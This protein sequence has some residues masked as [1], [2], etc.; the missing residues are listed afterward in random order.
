MR[1]QVSFGILPATFFISDLK[2]RAEQ[3][4]DAWGAVE[5]FYDHYREAFSQSSHSKGKEPESKTAQRRRDVTPER[6]D[7]TLDKV[8][9]ATPDGK[10]RRAGTPKRGMTPEPAWPSLKLKDEVRWSPRHYDDT[11]WENEIPTEFRGPL[12]LDM[13]KD[14]LSED[15]VEDK[16][17]RSWEDMR[18]KVRNLPRLGCLCLTRNSW[19]TWKH[20][21]ITQ[22]RR[23]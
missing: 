13:A 8:R 5:A 14:V 7:S 3:E 15:A 11:R 22:L 16:L 17:T 21:R 2:L 10:V 20:A 1:H 9:A 23:C 12:G 6:T 4:D 18:F 19:T